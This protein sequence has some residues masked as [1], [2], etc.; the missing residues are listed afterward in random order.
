MRRIDFSTVGVVVNSMEEV[1]DIY[2]IYTAL[3]IPFADIFKEHCIK[4][5][6]HNLVGYFIQINRVDLKAAL[7]DNDLAVSL[8]YY[9]IRYS[10][11]SLD[12]AVA[13]QLLQ[14]NE[15]D[16]LIAHLNKHC[17]EFK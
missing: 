1:D 5:Q 2:L 16:E 15:T 6:R 14:S 9:P 17:K 12:F 3:G 4:A 13:C 10:M 11:S 7:D 8:I